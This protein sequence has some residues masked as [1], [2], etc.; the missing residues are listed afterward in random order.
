MNEDIKESAYI[1]P[2]LSKKTLSLYY[3]A[4]QTSNSPQENH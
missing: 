3:K 1:K 2:G 4:L